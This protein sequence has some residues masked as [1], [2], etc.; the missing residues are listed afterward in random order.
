[1]HMLFVRPDVIAVLIPK[2]SKTI[3]HDQSSGVL[4]QWSLPV[5]LCKLEAHGGRDAADGTRSVPA[6]TRLLI[7]SIDEKGMSNLRLLI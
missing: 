3:C 1:M 6:T 2:L 4:R 5:D 7:V